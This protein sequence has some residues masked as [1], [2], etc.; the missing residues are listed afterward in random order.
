MAKKTDTAGVTRT[1]KFAKTAT[2]AVAAF[3]SKKSELL[4]HIETHRRTMDPFFALCEEYNA[5]VADAKDAIRDLPATDEPVAIGDFIRTRPS[6][7]VQ[8]DPSKLP[9]KILVLPGVVKA[10]DAKVLEACVLSGKATAAMV[11]QAKSETKGNPS[12]RGPAEITIKL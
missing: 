4:A 2:N 9:P 7:S 1:D 3:E 8:Y 11:N 10:V 5:A 6:H 12:V